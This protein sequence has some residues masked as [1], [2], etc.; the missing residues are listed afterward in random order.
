M[1]SLYEKKKSILYKIS[2]SFDLLCF[3]QYLINIFAES[4]KAERCTDIMLELTVYFLSVT[5]ENLSL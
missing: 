3:D 5:V 2:Y 4:K 1:I